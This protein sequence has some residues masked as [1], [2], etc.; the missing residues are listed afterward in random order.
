MSVVKRVL[1]L[2]TEGISAESEQFL[3]DQ[4]DEAVSVIPQDLIDGERERLEEAR[5]DAL[6]KS[7]VVARTKEHFR[8]ASNSGTMQTHC[9]IVCQKL[10]SVHFRVYVR[11]DRR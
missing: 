8:I 3:N 10:K 7:R 4:I 5:Q 11:S 2:L 9:H 1:K 6:Q